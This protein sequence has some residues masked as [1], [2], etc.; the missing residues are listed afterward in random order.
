MKLVFLGP[1]GAGKGTQAGKISAALHI[2]HISTGDMLRTAIA[3]QTPV[4]L[5][6]KAHMDE[7]RLVPDEVICAL[8]AER[9]A[10]GDCKNGFLLDGFPRTVP[11]AQALDG[12][13][14]L[15]AV[16]D[17]YVEPDALI[18]RLCG[19]RMCRGCGFIAHTKTL[20]AQGRCPKCGGEVYQ[21]DD[22]QPE[23]IATRLAVYE[24]KTKPLTD[25]YEQRGLLRRISGAG[26][27][28]DVDKDIRAALGI[29]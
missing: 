22:D 23:A 17:L 12:M 27:P 11:Q 16:V 14:N 4:G 3:N 13:T 5:A 29:S 9:I 21:R 24:Q 1:P 15:S 2:P 7:G 28:A 18:A 10:E 20:S 6:A 8:V 26:D 19:R 25:Y